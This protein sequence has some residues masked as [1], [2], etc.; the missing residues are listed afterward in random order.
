MCKS[1]FVVSY[2]FNRL[3]ILVF[4]GVQSSL[5]SI[6]QIELLREQQKILSGELALHSSA[7]KRL[8][9]EAA[10]NPQKEQIHVIFSF[11]GS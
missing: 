1:K 8:S 9:E 6:D 10:R 3:L 4:Y 2:I 5:K 11:L 7:L